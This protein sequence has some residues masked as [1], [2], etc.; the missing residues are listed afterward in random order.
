MAQ[1][2]IGFAVALIVLGVGGYVASGSVSP[3][4]LIPAFLGATLLILGLLA[5]DE[6]RRKTAMHIAVIVGLLG[7][8][9]SLPGLAKLPRLLAG[10]ALAR[11]M[12]VIAQ[13]VMAALTG[14]FVA[15]C[16]RSF[17][18]AKRSRVRI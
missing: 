6:R 7:F 2:T 9:G 3:T 10:E 14:I 12:A 15:L 13:S 18:M 4:A 16:V 5:R 11:P 8:L 1:I 17:I